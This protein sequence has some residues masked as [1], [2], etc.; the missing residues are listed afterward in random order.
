MKWILYLMLFVTPADNLS[1]AEKKSRD[2][3]ESNRIW[4]LQSTSTMVF[5][6]FD[7]CYFAQKELV[8][9][10]IKVDTL[11]IRTWCDCDSDSDKKACP[12]KAWIDQR[13]RDLKDQAKQEAKTEK[14]APPVEQN[15]RY[16]I[17]RL[18]PPVK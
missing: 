1:D 14:I 8:D 6:T 5:S 15:K 18:Y 16:M 4:T 10:V 2:V 12:N 7:A 11:T 3:F 13:I 17:Q 9:A